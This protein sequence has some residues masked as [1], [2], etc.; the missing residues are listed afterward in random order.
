MFAEA[1]EAGGADSRQDDGEGFVELDFA[2]AQLAKIGEFV[3]IKIGEEEEEYSAQEQ[4]RGADPFKF[5]GSFG[6]E[7]MDKKGAG[8]SEGEPAEDVVHHFGIAQVFVGLAG[9]QDVEIMEGEDIVGDAAVDG[10]AVI[11]DQSSAEVAGDDQQGIP[12]KTDGYIDD[13]GFTIGGVEE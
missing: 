12:G 9:R 11:E 5:V 10:R 2:I 3:E 8:E 7:G 6:K 4:E 13:Q 1:I